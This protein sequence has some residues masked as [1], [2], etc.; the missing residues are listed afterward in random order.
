MCQAF[1][2][3]LALPQE[4]QVSPVLMVA[5]HGLGLLGLLLSGV[6]SECCQFH[7][8]G[9]VFKRHL[10]ILGGTMEASFSATILF[11]V[12]WVAHV[13]IQ[14][15]WDESITKIVLQWDFGDALY[16]G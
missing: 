15:F 7:R 12:P 4:F 14:D 3:F 11:P 13:T 2:I 9:W 10:C 6:G 5:S 1:E 8:I 16:L